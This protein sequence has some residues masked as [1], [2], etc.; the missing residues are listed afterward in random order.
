M[1]ILTVNSNCGPYSMTLLHNIIIH[2]KERWV[3]VLSKE[4]CGN[5]IIDL[6]RAALVKDIIRSRLD[7]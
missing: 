7:S 1:V 4:V 3:N 6:V 2:G 5:I